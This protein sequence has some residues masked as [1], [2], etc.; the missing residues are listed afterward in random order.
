MKF[1]RFLDGKVERKGALIDGKIKEIQ[2]SFFDEYMITENTFEMDSV[3]ILPPVLPSKVVC[4]ARNYA[5]HAKELGNDVPTTPMIFMKPST[6]VIGHGDDIIFPEMSNQIDYE[7]ELAA[8]ISRKTKNIEPE[9]VDSCILGYTILNDITA[10]DLQ[11]EEGKFTRAKGFDTFCP[12]GQ[13]IDTEMGW[14]DVKIKTTVNDEVRQDGT[15][16]DMIFGVDVLIS[17]ISK[18]M[19]LLPGDVIATGTPP[20]VGPMNKG[21]IVTVEIEGLGKLVNNIK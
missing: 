11:K 20:G 3:K 19:T 5:A 12:I 2:G 14:K 15:T 9:E 1:L 13:Y 4:V 16:N 7:G 8:V 6:S 17:Y 10:R 18:I 21:D